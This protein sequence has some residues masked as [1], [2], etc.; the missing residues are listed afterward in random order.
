MTATHNQAPTE[1]GAFGTEFFKYFVFGDSTWDYTHY[2]LTHAAS[3]IKRADEL[4]SQALALDPTFSGAHNVKA[5]VLVDAG[6]V[7]E[8]IAE[9]ERAIASSRKWKATQLPEVYREAL[10]LRFQEGLTLEEI[11]VVT[12]AP[13]GTVK[14]RIY[15]GLNALQPYLNGAE[16]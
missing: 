2:D 15:R 1:Q 11:A 6:R 10:V 8:A 7:E 13:L 16:A 4:V 14:S 5:W 9:R 3:D 12:G